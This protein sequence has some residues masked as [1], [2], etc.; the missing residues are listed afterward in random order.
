MNATTEITGK[1]AV[2]L[3]RNNAIVQAW[4]AHEAY[5]DQ[6]RFGLMAI[7]ITLQSCLGGVA[8]MYVM[9]SGAGDLPL[10]L[11]AM[12]TMGA[13]AMFIAQAGARACL[14]A[15]YTALAIDTLLIGLY[16]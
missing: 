1:H 4:K 12:I 13:N 3:R 8:A 2:Q 16:F 7:L 9:E 10:I 14:I 11:C 6:N 15:C 5:F